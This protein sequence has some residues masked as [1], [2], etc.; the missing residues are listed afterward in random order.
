MNMAK[1]N[2]RNE[3]GSVTLFV[4][5]AMLFFI[6]VVISVYSNIKNKELVQAKNLEKIKYEYEKYTDMEAMD[7]KYEEI[8]GD[9]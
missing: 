6:I 8:L 9:K 4:L 2:K 7:N 5:V 3:K 1:K